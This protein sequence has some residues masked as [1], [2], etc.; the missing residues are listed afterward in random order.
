MAQRRWTGG[1]VRQN[2]DGSTTW[3]IEKMFGGKRFVAALSATTEREAE[4]EFAKFQADP[5]GYMKDRADE[6]RPRLVLFRRLELTPAL[7]DTFCRKGATRFADGTEVSKGHAASVRRS[8]L[9]WSR[10]LKGQSLRHL[11]T[12]E[13][14]SWLDRWETDRRGHASALK[15]LTRW[16]RRRDELTDEH[17]ATRNLVVPQPTPERRNRRKAMSAATI[18]NIYRNLDSQAARDEVRIRAATGQHG[19]EVS[20]LAR[21]QGMVTRI[22]GD[23]GIAGV[24][25]FKHKT[26][27]QHRVSVDAPTLAAVERLIGRG[28]TLSENRFTK[29][30]KRALERSGEDGKPGALRHSFGTLASEV[31]IQVKPV[32]RVGGVALDAVAEV[33]GHRSTRT[34]REFYRDVAVPNRIDLRLRLEH[35]DDP[36]TKLEFPLRR[37]E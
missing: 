19:R 21:G 6:R 35:P 22:D 9:K 14:E 32:G 5:D 30:W 10:A 15:S 8:L 33:L 7:I 16:L 2:L 13:L 26:G 1:R 12:S 4:A 31:G 20:R 27:A 17:D 18:E 29:I 25:E 24:I 34:T 37:G 23:P 3:V 11:R 36:S 28:K